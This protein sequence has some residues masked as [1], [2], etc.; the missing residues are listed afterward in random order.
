MTTA[1]ERWLSRHLDLTTKEGFLAA[2]DGCG[3]RFGNSEE[4]GEFL[5]DLLVTVEWFCL[6]NDKRSEVFSG[7]E[8]FSGYRASP[9]AVVVSALAHVEKTGSVAPEWAGKLTEAY[10]GL[11]LAEGA[12]ISSIAAYLGGNRSVAVV[13]VLHGAAIAE[14][15]V[16]AAEELTTLMEALSPES[17]EALHN[18]A[19]LTARQGDFGEARRLNRRVLELAPDW[20]PAL[21]LKTKL[22]KISPPL[23]R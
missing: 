23:K 1:T 7:S 17:V 18:K 9:R 20:Q 22:E 4:P 21:A 12:R 6:V 2:L 10:I 13:G 5:R 3:A 16:E 15:E 14:G 19:V 11:S 8:E